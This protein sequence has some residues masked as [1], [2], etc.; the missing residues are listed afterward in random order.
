MA[1]EVALNIQSLTKVYRLYDSP[2]DRLKESLHPLKK[3]YHSDFFALNNVSLDI[4]RGETFGIVGRNGSGK[5]TLLKIICGVLTPTAGSVSINGRI[6][7]LLELGTGFNPEMTGI[8]NVYFSGT[9]MGFKKE[10]MEEKLQSILSF[11]EIGEFI[12]QPVKT[13]SSGMFVRLAFAVA[14]NVDPD[15]LIVDEA[16]SVGDVAFQRKCFAKIQDIQK[17]GATIVFVSH[18]AGSIL[19][20]CKTAALMDAGEVIL[21]GNP[22]LVVTKYH[23][24]LF[25]KPEARNTI[26]EQIKLLS[27]EEGIDKT[28]GE[29][30][31]D[32]ELDVNYLPQNKNM[33]DPNMKPKSTVIYSEKEDLGVRLSDLGIVTPS[34]EQVNIINFGEE[35]IISYKAQFKKPAF[36]VRLG[37]M[38]KTVSG[39][40]LSGAVTS[41]PES[42]IDY[43]EEGA[44]VTARF[45]FRCLLHEGMYFVN[46]GVVGVLDG[47]ERYLE[48]IIDAFMFR[49]QSNRGIL[50]TCVVSLMFE[51]EHS[52]K[53]MA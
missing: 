31:A 24:M 39:Y 10:E 23:Q 17:K 7:A 34:G 38:I 13:Y 8:E 20:L 16:L 52:I 51:P 19:E 2:I 32:R 29:E 44:E 1:N 25:A 14:I 5:S 6:S 46:A 27:V 21:L 42:A 4:K 43:I 28:P 47:E 30:E 49:V 33:Y 11:A 48:R 50:S 41:T 45:R 53:R 12:K 3:Q 36:N 37:T 40:E 18:A 9:I 35:Y 22:K 26:R 15:V